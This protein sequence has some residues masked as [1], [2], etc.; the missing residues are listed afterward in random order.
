M[1]CDLEEFSRSVH[2]P[3]ASAQLFLTLSCVA[4]FIGTKTIFNTIR[5]GLA[6]TTV[7]VIGAG[8]IGLTAALIA[9]RDY[10]RVSKLILYEEQSKCCIEQKTYQISIQ[11]SVV[12]F[13]NKNGIDFDNLEGIWHEG[14]FYTRVGIYLEYIINILPLYKT[15]VELRFSSKV[16]VSLIF[17]FS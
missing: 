9:V 8:P 17:S 6:Q 7:V 2:S 1:R 16:G 11:P 15:E 10:K 3:N 12:S 4:V 5:R 13:L 14:C